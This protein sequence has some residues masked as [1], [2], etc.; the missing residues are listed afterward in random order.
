[1]EQVF[2][3]QKIQAEIFGNTLRAHRTICYHCAQGTVHKLSKLG[4][5]EKSVEIIQN[6]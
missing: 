2:S 5:G 4:K 1:M 3:V 6:F